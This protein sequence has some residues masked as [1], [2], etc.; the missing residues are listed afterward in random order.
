VSISQ[1]TPN[2]PAQK[3][4]LKTSCMLENFQ[5]SLATGA[6]ARQT[7]AS[8]VVQCGETIIL[9]P[10]V[11]TREANPEATFL[12]LS[13]QS[14]TK[15]YAR[16]KIP[17]DH[18]RR[19][20]YN[21][22]EA[23][24]IASRI[25]DRFVRASIPT[26]FNN[27]IQITP[28]LL[29]SDPNI[30]SDIPTMLGVSAALALSGLPY[31]KLTAS[32]RV[33]YIDEQFILNPTE[34][35]MQKSRL[36]FVMTG[37]EDGVIMIEASADAL[38]SEVLY[39]AIDFGLK[40]IQPVIQDIAQFAKQAGKPQW[41]WQ[42]IEENIALKEKI[43]TS[44]GA[45]LKGLYQMHD[46]LNRQAQREKIRERMI[47]ELLNEAEGT[48]EHQLKTLFRQVEADYMKERILNGQTR[49]DG[50][51]AR[52]IRPIT[53]ET[54][55][56]PRTHGSAVFTRGDT[57]ALVVATLGSD[58]DAQLVEGLHG[59]YRD[60]FILH[61]NF[62]PYSVGEVGKMGSPKRREI[63]HA[64]LAK[65][66]LKAVLPSESEWPY[67]LRVVSEIL[68]SNGSSSMATVCGASL[69]LMNAGVPLKTHVAGIA[70]GLVKSE[71]RFSILSDISADE[72]HIGDMDLKVAG[73]KDGITALQ[74]DIKTDGVTR[75]IIISAIQQAQE[76]LKHILS[77]MEEAMPG[78]SK[79]VSKY[80]PQMADM[81]IPIDKIQFLIG[82]GGTTIRRI[83]EE[84]GTLID[85]HRETGLIR[86]SAPDA[87]ARER[88]IALI[89]EVT[90]DSAQVDVNQIYEGTVVKL[91]QSGAFVSL[92]SGL[93]GFIHISELLRENPEQRVDELLKEK[94][95]IKVKVLE[96]DH[97]NRIK[98][99]MKNIAPKTD[100]L[101][102]AS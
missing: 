36:D 76:G 20:N 66:A 16:G 40:H 35:D 101:S 38:K 48:T 47:A 62:P 75:E 39:E 34:A 100:T 8:V 12:P 21:H 37:T 7:T 89:K 73:T 98:L 95:R 55:L 67:V 94:Q 60:T 53:I 64:T 96:I 17:G 19:E 33:G 30:R 92:V 11:A 5:I 46:K 102:D 83:T 81:T 72:D 15:A 78:P 9:V 59:P 6:L 56:L 63:G 4:D 97:Q 44:A 43:K 91:T 27:E 88:A 58:R 82:K 70:M 84:T 85:I 31:K 26:G 22:N 93:R 65:R 68:E 50:R 99:T 3:S 54:G 87:E 79:E 28:T 52:D 80:A 74:M 86:I 57:Q 77:K 10:L 2:V 71:N 1:L 25:A 42:P 51:G 69:A 49:L 13:V 23:D 18:R 61:Y 29:S 14:Q 32:A 24:I 41:N 45:E 90:E